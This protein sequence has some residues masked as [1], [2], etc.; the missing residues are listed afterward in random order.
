MKAVRV[1]QW[2]KVPAFKP[3]NWSSI[4]GTGMGGEKGLSAPLCF[5]Q[6]HCCC[7]LLLVVVV[8]GFSFILLVFFFPLWN[9]GGFCACSLGQGPFP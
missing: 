7:L 6:Q 3:E 1:G 5:T 9:F 2:I 4:P 8:W